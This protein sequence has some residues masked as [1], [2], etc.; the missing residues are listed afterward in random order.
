V[1]NH[2]STIYSKL[3]VDN[4]AQAIVLAQDKGFGRKAAADRK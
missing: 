1:R 4:R 3:G 2:L